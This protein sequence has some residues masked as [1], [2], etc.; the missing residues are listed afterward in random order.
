[1]APLAGLKVVEIGQVLA[2]PFAGAIF[3]DLGA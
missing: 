3:S 1:M 2:G